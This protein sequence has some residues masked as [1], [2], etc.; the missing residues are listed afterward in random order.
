M[1]QSFTLSEI[2]LNLIN[3]YFYQY[4]DTNLNAVL[5]DFYH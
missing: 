2:R 1:K 3:L 4:L 5:G